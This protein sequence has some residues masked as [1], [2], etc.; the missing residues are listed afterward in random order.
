MRLRAIRPIQLIRIPL[1]RNP[2][3]DYTLAWITPENA[4]RTERKRKCLEHERTE[5]KHRPR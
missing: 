1:I 2:R 3:K 5:R 4:K